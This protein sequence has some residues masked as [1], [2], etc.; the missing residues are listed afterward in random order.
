MY[1]C[2]IPLLIAHDLD[3][4]Q[5]YMLSTR[6]KNMLNSKNVIGNL[7]EFLKKLR[8]ETKIGPWA[9]K[10]GIY[11]QTWNYL[12]NQAKDMAV[13]RLIEIK[14]KLGL[15]W[16]ALGKMLEEDEVFKK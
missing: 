5:V 13:S 4:W 1:V 11:P 10:L 6:T 3:A 9:K 16:S 7:M 14:Q 8:G 2:L 12:E 15:T